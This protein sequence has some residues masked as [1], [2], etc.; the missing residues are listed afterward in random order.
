ML[1]QVVISALSLVVLFYI[2]G[3]ASIQSYIITLYIAFGS[4][5]VLSLHLLLR[6]AE[7]LRRV[8]WKEYRAASYQMLHYGLLNQLAH[9]AQLLSFRMSYYWLN[10]L[11]GQAEVGIYSNGASLVES[12]WLVSRSI[13]MV[14]YAHIA[15]S[16]DKAHSQ[17]LTVQLT[18]AAL[19]LSAVLLVVLIFLPSAFFVWLFGPGFGQV[20]AVIFALAPGVLLFNVALIVGHYFSG[21]GKYHVNTIAS[22]AGLVVAVI[23]YSLMIPALGING[24]GW[25]TSI[26]YSFTS[27]IVVLFFAREMIIHRSDFIPRK[28]EIKIMWEQMMHSIGKR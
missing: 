20:G 1:L 16:T 17:K 12:I 3:L 8:A 21:T 23:L 15:N 26:S 11:Y 25:A 27:L 28:G 7:G 13:S 18:L 22:F 6:H 9:I 2:A 19:V 4:A 10:S 24:A 5:F 14:Q